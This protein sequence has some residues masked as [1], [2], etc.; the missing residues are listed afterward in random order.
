MS[1]ESWGTEHLASGEYSEEDW[2][3]LGKISQ[4][5]AAEVKGNERLIARAFL[6]DFKSGKFDGPQRIDHDASEETGCFV[7]VPNPNVSDNID[8]RWHTRSTDDLG[9]ERWSLLDSQSAQAIFADSYPV[10]HGEHDGGDYFWLCKE[11]INRWCDWHDLPRLGSW[12]APENQPQVWASRDEILWAFKLIGTSKKWKIPELLDE[13]ARQLGKHVSR[14]SLNE[15]K[16][17]AASQ[18]LIR[19]YS[20]GHPGKVKHTALS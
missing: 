8:L 1:W 9:R 19:L 20:R 14:R 6:K 18:G 4:W 11:A 10:E 7:I 17:N 3:S 2:F 16:N 13:V 15:V 5:L 12:P